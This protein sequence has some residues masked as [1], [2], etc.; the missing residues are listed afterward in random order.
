M[1]CPAGHDVIVSYHA[2][3]AAPSHSTQDSF[4]RLPPWTNASLPGREADFRTV[5]A[6]ARHY[7]S[8][9][10]LYGWNGSETRER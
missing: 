7:N 10:I 4:W 5:K 2:D 6:A 3:P 1:T 9:A 8:N